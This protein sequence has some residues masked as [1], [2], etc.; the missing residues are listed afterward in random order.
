MGTKGRLIRCFPGPAVAISRDRVLDSKFRKVLT[1]CLAD[2]NNQTIAEATPTTQ[3][4][5]NEVVEIR[6]S[7]DP[8]FV[9]EMLTG[10]LRGIGRTVGT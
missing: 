7:I 9:T 4:A 1:Q 3:K 8:K 6:D 5:G 2:L 10:I